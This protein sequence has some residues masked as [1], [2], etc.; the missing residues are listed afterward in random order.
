[1]DKS[2]FQFIWKYS[3]H[4]QLVL[5]GVTLLTFPLLYVSLEL[6]KRIINDAIGGSGNDVSLLGL[7]LSQIQF[8]LVLCFGFLLA[9]LANGLLKMQLN[10]MKGVLAERLLRR[11]RFQ[12]LTRILRFPRPFFRTTSQGELVSMVT[13]EAEPMGRLMGDMLSQPVFQ[14][15]QMMTILIFLFA[16]SF[17][18]GLASVALIPLQ[19]WIIPKLQRQINLLNKARIQEV[20]KLA[21]D[22]GETAVGVSDIRING[23]L[24]NRMSL[25]SDRLGSLFGIRLA[26]Y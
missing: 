2:L 6:P 5:L 10:T 11:F 24:R 20:R 3:K 14:A 26:I 15:G 18:F 21:A 1:M 7:S 23:G 25:F 9:V 17:W 8:L 19:A 4:D 12:L 16:Q 13:S 22:I